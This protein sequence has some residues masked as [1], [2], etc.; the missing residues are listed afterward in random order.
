MQ[1]HIFLKNPSEIDFSKNQNRTVPPPTALKHM[2]GVGSISTPS[3]PT[4]LKHGKKPHSS[5]SFTSHEGQVYHEKQTIHKNEKSGLE[6]TIQ[7]AVWLELL[8]LGS[9]PLTRLHSQHLPSFGLTDPNIAQN[10][11]LWLVEEKVNDIVSPFRMIKEHE[12]RPVDEPCSLLKRLQWRADR[13][14]ETYNIGVSQRN[15]HR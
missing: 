9:N 4:P 5:S 14:K 6:K 12:Q 1:D 13:L 3:Y 2:V 15:L 8:A 11:L 7:N 10:S